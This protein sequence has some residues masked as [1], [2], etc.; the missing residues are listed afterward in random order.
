M[1]GQGVERCRELGGRWTEGVGAVFQRRQQ[2]LMQ[3]LGAI[4][5]LVCGADDGRGLVDRLLERTPSASP[6]KR[7]PAEEALQGQE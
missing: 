4:R 1:G 7:K 5:G 6:T 2:R 3:S